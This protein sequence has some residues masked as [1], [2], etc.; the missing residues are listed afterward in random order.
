[1]NTAYSAGKLCITKPHYLPNP[2]REMPAALAKDLH[3][4]LADN[5][6]SGCCLVSG[7]LGDLSNNAFGWGRNFSIIDKFGV[8]A[9]S[10]E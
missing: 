7:V 8:P 1:M 9:F 2:L 6:R 10:N 4:D 3:T 5:Q